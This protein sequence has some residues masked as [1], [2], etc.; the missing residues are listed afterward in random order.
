MNKRR[1]TL[2]FLARVEA[3]SASAHPSA[4]VRLE[5]IFSVD[6]F[7]SNHGNAAMLSPPAI[8]LKA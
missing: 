3:V 1:N 4:D 2:F 6:N 8:V 5:V 7:L